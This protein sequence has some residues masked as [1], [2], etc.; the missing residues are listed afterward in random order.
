MQNNAFN[1]HA[2][3]ANMTAR[4]VYVVIY[5]IQMRLGL[6][7]GHD[8]GWSGKASQMIL[9]TLG[10]AKKS[11]TTSQ[12]TCSTPLALENSASDPLAIQHR[13]LEEGTAATWQITLQ[14]RQMVKVTAVARTTTA[15]DDTRKKRIMNNVLKTIKKAKS[16]YE[17]V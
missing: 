11:R 1:V 7:K 4:Q 14:T 12:A 2:S 10:K 6:S 15:T 5:N 13:V 9:E 17:G 8:G 16:K 3:R